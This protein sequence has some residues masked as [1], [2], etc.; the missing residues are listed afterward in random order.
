MTRTGLVGG[1]AAAGILLPMA[2]DAQTCTQLPLAE[3][4]EARGVTLIDRRVP[5]TRGDVVC[6]SGP[7]NPGK[8]QYDTYIYQWGY[9]FY[10]CSRYRSCTWVRNNDMEAWTAFC[11]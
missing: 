10:S 4:C 11:N 9:E 1:L 7:A 6:Q 3:T 8:V 2:G 5:G